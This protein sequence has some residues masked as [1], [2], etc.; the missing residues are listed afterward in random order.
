M[1]CANYVLSR[2]RG[3]YSV[4]SEDSFASI[5]VRKIFYLIL[6]IKLKVFILL[7]ASSLITMASSGFKVQFTRHR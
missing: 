6:K 2:T 5:N 1:E 4:S 7:N 3:L